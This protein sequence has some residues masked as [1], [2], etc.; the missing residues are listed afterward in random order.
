VADRPNLA[1]QAQRPPEA[2]EPS[3]LFGPPPLIAGEDLA[4]YDALHA[5]LSAAVKPKDMLEQ[6]WTRDVVD[7]TWEILRMRRFKA[8]LLDSFM[9]DA[10]E[11]L[12]AGPLGWVEAGDLSKH[13]AMRNP[14]A[15]G[16]VDELLSSMELPR[17]AV[18]ARAWSTHLADF[19]RIDRAMMQAEVRR[20]AAFREIDRHRATLA[21]ALRQASDDVIEAEFKD[22][23]KDPPAQ[24]HVA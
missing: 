14:Q 20:N 4:G 15:I 18:A 11:R 21:A 3:S 10:V 5:R 23:A 13:W 6:I 9:P 19:E 16:K 8:T 7:L 22:V 24:K 17:D 2:L 12:L 1:I